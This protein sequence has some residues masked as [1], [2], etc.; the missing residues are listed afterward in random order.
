MRRARTKGFTLVELIVTIAIVAILLAVAL[1]SFEGS[2]RSNR[3]AT[4]SNELLASIALARS[5][6]MQ[7]P[8]GAA[9]CTTSNGTACNGA[10]WNDGWMVWID[11]NGDGSPTGVNDRV[12]RHVAALPKVA[13]SAAAPGGAAAANKVRF[14]RRGRAIDNQ[15][16]IELEP[17]VCPAGAMLRREFTLSPTGQTRMQRVTCS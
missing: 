11:M 10:S 7:S 14:D 3:V 8:G 1:P 9:I 15:V 13:F 4:A 6:A 12:V 16:A 17:D 2:M 5:E